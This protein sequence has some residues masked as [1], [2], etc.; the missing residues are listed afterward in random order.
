[1]EFSELDEF[2]KEFKRLR[3]KHPSFD[4]DF[5]NVKE[6][7]ECYPKGRGEK[8][9]N[10]LKRKEPVFIYKI[11]MRCRSL[12]ST[13]IRIIYLYNETKS[14]ITFIEV[15]YK[16]EKENEDRE[17]YDSVFRDSII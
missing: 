14:K 11:R 7:I 16:G 4:E 10:L 5:R 2:A 9:W 12:Q 17:R 8:H 3:K 15:Y 13:E 6:I 1:M